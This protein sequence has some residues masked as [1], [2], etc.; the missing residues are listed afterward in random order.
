[1]LFEKG[2]ESA[3]VSTGAL[4]LNIAGL[5]DSRVCQIEVPLLTVAETKKLVDTYGPEQKPYM[6]IYTHSCGH[7]VLVRTLC[8]YL[9]A[10][11]WRLDEKHFSNLLAYSF[12]YNL[13]RTMADLMRTLLA[14]TTDRA[15]LN[16]L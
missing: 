6:F 8:E 15:L 12:D 2:G 13:S 7:P 5:D 16:R 10:N 3:L 4:N 11:H 14:D 9:K 1:M